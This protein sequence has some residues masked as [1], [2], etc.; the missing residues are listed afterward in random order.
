SLA[1][2]PTGLSPLSLHDA[3][4]ICRSPPV[5]LR[6]NAADV[7]GLAVRRP[8]RAGADCPWGGQSHSPARA[9][10]R[11]PGAARVAHAGVAGALAGDGRVVDSRPCETGCTPGSTVQTGSA[12]CQGRTATGRDGYA[13]RR[14]RGPGRRLPTDRDGFR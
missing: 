3:L 7:A 11:W 1:P 14:P 2:A 9:A 5:A 4:P 12:D 10:D 6:R 13:R 8:A